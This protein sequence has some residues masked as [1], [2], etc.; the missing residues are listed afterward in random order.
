MNRI[1]TN[2]LRARILMQYADEKEGRIYS[3]A[4]RMDQRDIA[5]NNESVDSLTKLVAT[6]IQ[7]TDEQRD[8]LLQVMDLTE[9]RPDRLDYALN[10]K[11]KAKDLPAALAQI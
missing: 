1:D 2:A 8:L 11:G 6:F 10:W 3:A 9:G 7:M 4:M 5:A